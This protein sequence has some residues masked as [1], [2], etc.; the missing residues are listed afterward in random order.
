MEE[1]SVDDTSQRF[2]KILEKFNES[3]GGY[4][5]LVG[6]DFLLGQPRDG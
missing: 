3:V 1:V 5:V 2:W 6:G 4:R